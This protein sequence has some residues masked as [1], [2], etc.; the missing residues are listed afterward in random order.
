MMHCQ[1]L[2]M[3]RRLHKETEQEKINMTQQATEKAAAW[4]RES[5]IYQIYPRSFADSNGDG[6][7][8]LPG[9][10]AKLPYVA[11]LG[12][13][14]V[15]ISPFFKSPMADFGYDVSDYCDV[16]PL[17]GTLEDFDRLLDKAH[18]LGLKIMIDQVLSHCS[19]QHPWFV[20]SR[21]DRS[22]PKADWFVWADP[23]PD[24][25][26]PNNWLSVFGGSSWQWDARRRQYYL[27]NFLTSQPDLNFHNPQVQQALLDAMRFWLARGV[28]GFRL[29]ACNFHFHDRA[30]R[31]NPPATNRDTK[32]VQDTN[33][34]GM[35]AHIYDKT[36][37]ENL[38]FLQRV[39]ALLNEYGAIA[40]GEV[41]ADDSLAVMAEYTEGDDKL[42]MAYSFNLLTPSVT[43]GYIREQVEQYESRVK[44]GWVS[45]SVGNHDVARVMSRWGGADATPAF[46]KMMY[47]LQM[48]LRGT[49]C[50]YQGDELGLTE[51][52][53]AFEDLQDPYGK[54]FWPEFKG[55]DGCRTPMP[56]QA[57]AP[58]AGFSEH[59]PWLP[60]PVEHLPK[61]ADQ[62]ESDPESVLNYVRHILR[63]RKQHAVLLHGDIAFADAPEPVLVVRRTLGEQVLFAAF[64][65]S[66]E[67]VTLNLPKI[68]AT[69]TMD[70][71]NLPS[72]RDGTT[73]TL[74]A[75]GGW[76][77]QTA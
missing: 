28:D 58:F 74:P 12:V 62:Q 73:L 2:Q 76:F 23:Q 55:R 8:D 61:A 37:P 31:S 40:I 72:Q 68:A 6:I 38:A 29:D 43:A 34:Y 22:N 63:W 70:G 15:W 42:H 75:W 9:I 1:Y 69:K 10:T 48:A 67:S 3:K 41:G 13:D 52:E 54:T 64:N 30:L 33:P 66:A 59:K 44:G 60:V 49:P 35:Q 14:I 17:F 27:H 25:T 51:A 56:W 65:L 77:G 11:S 57:A 47:A 39:R 21:Q 24:G 50:L 19:D 20:E 16:D 4:W 71:V 46:A 5:T 7:G 53:I 36:Q 18:Q 32:T 45:W 26:P